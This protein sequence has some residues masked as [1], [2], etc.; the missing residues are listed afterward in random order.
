MILQVKTERELITSLE[1]LS[2]I[3]TSLQT[4][5]KELNKKLD[6]MQLLL[7]KKPNTVIKE[8]VIKEVEK[9][10]IRETQTVKF[11][12]IDTK[13]LKPICDRLKALEAAKPTKVMHTKEVKL[14][15]SVLPTLKKIS[16]R[17]KALE[18]KKPSVEIKETVIKEIEKPTINNTTVVKTD[19]SVLPTLKKLSDRIKKIEDAKPE[20]IEKETIIREIEKPIIELKETIIKEIEKPT[21]KEVTVLKTDPSILPA[22]K[23][24]SARLKALEDKKPT[25]ELKETV[26]KEVEKP[27]I[28]KTTVVKTDPSVLPTLKKISTRLKTL[29]DKSPATQI[30]K[31]LTTHEVKSIDGSSKKELAAIK[32]SIADIKPVISNV[33]QGVTDADVLSIIDKH[34]TINYVNKLYKKGK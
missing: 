31:E 15:P 27:T 9:P 13:I 29:E 22:L 2:K 17:L 10:T 18:D 3:V 21:I 4:H 26:I 20:V 5:N 34:V 28:K 6:D 33:T 32:K 14:D 11:E 19:K 7:D 25:I 24:L 1:G 30:I 16:D 23:K 12:P 8:T